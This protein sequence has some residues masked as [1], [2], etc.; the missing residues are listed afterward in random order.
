MMRVG[1]LLVFVGFF[2][3]FLSSVLSFQSGNW[4]IILFPFIF[5]GG[6]W[7]VALVMFLFLL[8]M[9]LPWILGMKWFSGGGFK[10]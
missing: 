3:I 2:L 7:V 4:T 9:L 8:F 6:S 10:E 1:M 5:T